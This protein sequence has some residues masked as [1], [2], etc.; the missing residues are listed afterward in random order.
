MSSTLRQTITDL[1]TTFASGVLDAIRG[2][3][4]EEILSETGRK[5]ATPSGGRTVSAAGTSRAVR[6]DGRLSR[7][8]EEDIAEVV[9]K[10]TSLLGKSPDGLRAEQIRD[11]LGLQAKELPRPLAEALRSKQVT[12]K[13]QKRATTYFIKDGAGARGAKPGRGK[14]A[15]KAKRGK[16]RKAKA[17]AAATEAAA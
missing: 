14:G 7:R 10:I 15:S 11:A 9:G 2:A 16:G 3:S 6:P 17:E 4:L 12:K 5:G 13:G 1:A 8:S